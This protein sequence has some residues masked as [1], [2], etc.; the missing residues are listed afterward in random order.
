MT[1]LSEGDWKR[2][3][4]QSRSLILT[5]EEG[6]IKTHAVCSTYTRLFASLQQLHSSSP[7]D[8][9]SQILS[10]MNTATGLTP[11]G[12]AVWYG[13]VDKIKQLLKEHVDVNGGSRPPLWVAASRPINHAGRI[14]DM[15][16]EAGADP[17]K[18]STID[19]NSTPLLGAVKLSQ[20]PDIIRALVDHGADPTI[21]DENGDTARGVADKKKDLETLKALQ[22]RNDRALNRPKA[23]LVLTGL[24]LFVVAWANKNIK[25]TTAAIVAGTFIAREAIKKRFNMSG[26]FDKII[27][28]VC[29]CPTFTS[30]FVSESLYLRSIKSA[31]MQKSSKRI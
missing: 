31:K 14:I 17:N 2:M 22:P 4:Y 16:L 20:P 13:K 15:L 1:H 9:I 12:E 29:H 28:E 11:L 24:L 3:F 25:A 26:I 27:P 6:V 8:A 10:N 21:A 19:S 23:V 18:A 5:L 30:R 7:L